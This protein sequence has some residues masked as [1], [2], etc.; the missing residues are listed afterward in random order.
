VKIMKRVLPG[1]AVI[2]ERDRNAPEREVA[3][4]P[5]AA[6]V[7]SMSPPW[8]ASLIERLWAALKWL[9]SKEQLPTTKLWLEVIAV[10]VGLIGGI[11]ALLGWTQR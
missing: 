10:I 5:G 11:L 6:V 3:C 1:G 7:E 9:F 2:G 4:R 8:R